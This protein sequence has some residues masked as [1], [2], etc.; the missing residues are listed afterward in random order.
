MDEEEKVI[1]ELFRYL[2]KILQVEGTTNSKSCVG[3]K[4]CKGRRN[5]ALF[6]DRKNSVTG[7]CY[8]SRR[9]LGS[10]VG[11]GTGTRSILFGH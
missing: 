2:G 6:T 1:E 7:E 8:L 11:E 5:P 9:M 4:Q 3:N 10:E